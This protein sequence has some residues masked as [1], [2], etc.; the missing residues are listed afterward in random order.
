MKKK[1]LVERSE[2]DVELLKHILTMVMESL[3]G[4]SEEYLNDISERLQSGQPVIFRP[5]KE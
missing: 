1:Q 2:A 3:A 5:V 4:E